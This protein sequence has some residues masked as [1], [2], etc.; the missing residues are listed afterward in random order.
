MPKPQISAKQQ[1]AEL[2]PTLRALEILVGDWE[3][4]I[5]NAA[6][7]PDASAKVTCRTSIQWTEAG[8]YLLMRQAGDD[9]G[10]PNGTWLISG[11]EATPSYAVSYFDSR[12]V[13]RIYQ[14]SFEESVCTMWRTAPGFSQRFEGALSGSGELIAGYWEK[15]ADGKTWEHDFDMTFRRMFPHRPRRLT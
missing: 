11:D 5:S 14:M 13:S 4:E 2:N 3:T 1:R 9:P 7:L 10:A 12:G 6:S 15:S 8:A